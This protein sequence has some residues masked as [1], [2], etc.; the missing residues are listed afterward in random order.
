M[1]ENLHRH[2]LFNLRYRRRHQQYNA[3]QAIMTTANKEKYVLPL[4]GTG[5][6]LKP[7]S[8]LSNK[9]LNIHTYIYCKV[10][11]PSPVWKVL[12]EVGFPGFTSDTASFS[13]LSYR[14]L[15]ESLIGDKRE[16][17]KKLYVHLDRTS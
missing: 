6:V 1:T 12:S 9:S 10:L 15:V 8:Y 7:K 11:L 4:L 14:R 3:N 16:I 2:T 17:G 13:F 5:F